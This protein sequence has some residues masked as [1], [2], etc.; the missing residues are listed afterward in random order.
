LLLYTDAR[1]LVFSEILV[2]KRSISMYDKS[3]LTDVYFIQ[4]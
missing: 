2:A 4:S 3:N 1:K